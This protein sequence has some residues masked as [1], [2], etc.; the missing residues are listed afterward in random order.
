M[1]QNQKQQIIKIL[2]QITFLTKPLQSKL[3]QYIP[4]L[5]DEYIVYLQYATDEDG[6]MKLLFTFIQPMIYTTQTIQTCGNNLCT[7][8][9]Q[10]ETGQYQLVILEPSQFQSFL[11]EILPQPSPIL[12]QMINNI[13]ADEKSLKEIEYQ[14]EEEELNP[15]MFEEWNKSQ[16][17]YHQ[18]I[19]NKWIERATKT[20]R[21]NKKHA[22]EFLIEH[23]IDNQ[24]NRMALERIRI[25]S[26][27]PSPIISSISSEESEDDERKKYQKSVL[28]KEIRKGDYLPGT[29][30]LHTNLNTIKLATRTWFIEADDAVEF[31]TKEG[32]RIKEVID[33]S[34]FMYKQQLIS[35]KS[36]IDT[37]KRYQSLTK[38][39][40]EKLLECNWNKDDKNCI[41]SLYQE[42]LSNQD[43]LINGD[44]KIRFDQKLKTLQKN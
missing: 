43:P 24:Q 40:L 42:K 17:E 34:F 32:E 8:I 39:Y 37:L 28:D 27:S 36:L 22:H 10:H 26:R 23:D 21:I 4:P 31:F 6:D 13:Q 30:K 41:L 1:N 18:N 5:L 2:T 44:L 12:Q 35:M 19:F 14:C 33:V 29:N 38:Y 7:S 16:K 15:T 20:G 11:S 25:V 3:L 9:I